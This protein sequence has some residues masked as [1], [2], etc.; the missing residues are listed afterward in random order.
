MSKT[1]KILTKSERE[2]LNL[3]KK[4][5]KNLK[6]G[7]VIG[8]IGELGAGKTVLIK[9]L[10]SGL[11]F[12]KTITSPSFVLM[13]IYQIDDLKSKIETVI[14]VDAY[15][16]EKGKDLIDIGLMDYLEKP[17][18]VTVIE[19]ADKVKDILPKKTIFIKIKIKGKREREV[20][21]TNH[22]NFSQI[23][24]NISSDER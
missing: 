20:I 16:L 3:G 5:A 9:G 17:K 2:T 7:E 22:T 23:T 13:K 11:G 14:H 18:T 6:G 1:Q 15:R 10:V 24:T 12:K 8:L 21:I 19:W 4:I